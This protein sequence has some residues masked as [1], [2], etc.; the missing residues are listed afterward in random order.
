SGGR[1]PPIRG[2][3]CSLFNATAV[4]S[5]QDDREQVRPPLFA[6][7]VAN[8]HSQKESRPGPKGTA[9]RVLTTSWG[10]GDR[11]DF[12]ACPTRIH[13]CV[14]TTPPAVAASDNK[15]PGSPQAANRA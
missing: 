5:S 9:F 1:L 14:L 13:G 11:G 2:R 12:A 15:K 8:P 6:V 3:N 7:L 10:R 4:R